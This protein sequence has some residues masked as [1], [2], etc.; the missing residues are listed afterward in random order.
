MDAAAVLLSWSGGKDAAWTLH[1]LR[2]QGVAV[3][4]LVTT[5]TAGYER[6]SMQGIRRDVLHA[7]AAATGLPLIEAMIPPRCDN[8]TYEAAFA[9]ALAQARTRWPQVH[10]IAFGDLFLQDIRDYR[11]AMCA[12]LDWQVRTPLFGS[13]TALLAR[14]MLA[15]GLGAAICCVDTEQLPA[16]FAGRD[17]DAALL[18]E[19]SATLDPCGENGEFHTCVHA[20]P[21]FDRPI[22]V[23][24][25]E[26]V[27]RDRRFA[28]TD[29]TLL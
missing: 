29:F 11:V 24:R 18:D 12:R 28:Y 1:R 16:N 9:D 20:G 25:G 14:E 8:A 4:G 2:Q 13:D 17:F 26:T 10:S 6:V 22:R 23:E 21:M 27:L 15:G 19:L 5:V 3:A 7:Q